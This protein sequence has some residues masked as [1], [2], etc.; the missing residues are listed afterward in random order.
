MKNIIEQLKEQR[1][2]AEKTF[3]KNSLIKRN[4]M[5]D[6]VNP[7][8]NAYLDDIA[9]LNEAISVLENSMAEKE[10]VFNCDYLTSQIDPTIVTGEQWYNET[11]NTKEK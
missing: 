8:T 1:E 7:D 6:E 4:C 2:K 11:F 3:I 5:N 10:P 9:E